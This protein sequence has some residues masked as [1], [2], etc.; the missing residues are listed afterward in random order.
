M[1][2]GFSDFKGTIMCVGAYG[3]W[4]DFST[5]DPVIKRGGVSIVCRGDEYRM[6]V[7]SPKNPKLCI[8]IGMSP[9]AAA[10]CLNGLLRKE[11]NKEYLR[12]AMPI[13][14]G[15]IRFTMKLSGPAS[16]YTF[17]LQGIDDPVQFS[18]SSQDL[19]AMKQAILD[20]G[21]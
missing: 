14:F 17:S 5:Y 15:G 21:K 1:R 7:G 20:F 9:E 8:L 19:E 12:T 18:L 16:N 13:G 4:V 3:Q 10:W 11:N 6:I 2:I